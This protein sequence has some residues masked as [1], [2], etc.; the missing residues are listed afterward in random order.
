M[1]YNRKNHV[2]QTADAI[3]EDMGYDNYAEFQADDIEYIGMECQCNFQGVCEILNIPLPAS[4]GPVTD[5]NKEQ[6]QI[7]ARAM[8]E[9]KLEAL[10]DIFNQEWTVM[11]EKEVFIKDVLNA[12]IKSRL[13]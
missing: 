8:P 1:A 7:L 10:A 2:I 5:L 11:N 6:Y 4:L 13:E 9:K 12:E 3:C